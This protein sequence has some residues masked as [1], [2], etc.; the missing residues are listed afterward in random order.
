MLGEGAATGMRLVRARLCLSGACRC[1]TD[2]RFPLHFS[3]LRDS[4][5]PF[6]HPLVEPLSGGSST[7]ER[8]R[9]GCVSTSGRILTLSK[10]RYKV[11]QALL[12]QGA[13][14][15]RSAASVRRGHRPVVAQINLLCKHHE[16]W[17]SLT[18]D[19]GDAGLHC[20]HHFSLRAECLD[21]YFQ[22]FQA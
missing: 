12:S 14:C 6:S 18:G 20:V 10:S 9:E 17:Q 15:P 21:T 13:M 1:T 4:P 19:V 11:S 22:L 2:T 3:A 16:A 7:V 8:R 5:I